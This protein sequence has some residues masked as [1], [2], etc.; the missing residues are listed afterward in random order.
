[1]LRCQVCCVARVLYA[2]KHN[3]SASQDPQVRNTSP[4]I[5]SKMCHCP[6]TKESS[7]IVGK[8]LE[9]ECPEA[10]ERERG[11]KARFGIPLG[12]RAPDDAEDPV[13]LV[14]VVLGQT[15]FIL[16]ELF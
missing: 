15:I 12:V 7:Q 2:I 10:G 8:H 3:Q 5:H 11:R 4:E 14:S 13:T 1:M 16:G 6:R 9:I